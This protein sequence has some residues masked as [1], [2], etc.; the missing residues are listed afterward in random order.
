MNLFA[1]ILFL[2]GGLGTFLIGL[3]IMSDNLQ[4]IAGDRLKLLFNKVSNNKF[5]GIATGAGITAVIQSSSATTVMIVGFVNAGL[6]TLKQATSIIMGANIG[7]TI[8]AQITALQSLP[9]TPFLTALAC[10]G[11]FM[12]MFGK[13]KVA[14]IGMLISGIG[15]I[16]VGMKFM[17]ISMDDVS[18]SQA[19][20]NLLSSATNPLLLMLIGLVFTAIF[21]SSAAT[22]S[23]LI[24]LCSVSIDGGAQLMTLKSAIFV[25]LGINIGTCVTAMLASIGANTNAKRAS[26]IHLLFN[27]FGTA[28]FLIFIFV[29]PLI[30]KKL[31]M[32]YWLA[33]A[34]PNVVS[35]QI[36]MFHTIFNIISTLVLLPFTGGLTKLATLIVREKKKPEGEESEEV[37]YKF[38]FIDE[39]ILK[40]P[41]IALMMLRKEVVAMARLSKENFD[42]A[43]ECIAELNF[44]K[45]KEFE[46][47][48]KKID[49]LNKKLTKYAVKISTKDISYKEEKE[50]ASFYHAISDIERVGDYAENICESAQELVDYKLSFSPKAIEELT[51]MKSAVDKLYENVITAFESKSLALKEEVD[52]YE[53]LVDTYNEDLAKNHI[54]R[55]HNNECSSES[56]GIFLSIVSNMERIADHFRNVFKSMDTYVSPVKIKANVKDNSNNGIQPVADVVENTDQDNNQNDNAVSK[57]S[58]NK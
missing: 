10:V 34:F 1:S 4:N 16:F 27:V 41:S 14:K 51:M 29:A 30:S 47:R 48:E 33:K 37:N 35:T 8:T 52:G 21:Q 13:N 58:Q 44:D 50:I 56:G 31:A 36:A 2:L 43:F 12:A 53:D 20:I 15:I 5:M 11:A 32:D 26:V 7:T 6:M 17:S 40:T 22:T 46:D 38:A 49:F 25:T 3:K 42:I 39:R 45:Q 18:K 57:V 28:I 9:I 55:L 54:A 24:T 23:I 19:V